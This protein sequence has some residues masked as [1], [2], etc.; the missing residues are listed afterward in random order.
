MSTLTSGGFVGGGVVAF[1]A[2][3]AFWAKSGELRARRQRRKMRCMVRERGDRAD[4]AALKPCLLLLITEV[5]QVDLLHLISSHG[6]H[7]DAEVD[8]QSRQ[9]VAVDQNDL[10]INLGDIVMRLACEVRSGD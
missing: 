9:R 3:A 6:I 2:F 10:G 7:A 1:L 5:I 4:V 8:H